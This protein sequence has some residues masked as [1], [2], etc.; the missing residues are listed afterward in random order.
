MK[1]RKITEKALGAFEKSLRTEEKSEH[2][3]EKYMRDIR[4]FF[5]FVKNRPLNKEMLLSYKA[6]LA[7]KYAPS[8]ANSM[9]AAVNSF[10]RFINRSDL[11][12]RQFKIQKKAYCS[13]TKELSQE[14]YFSLIKTAEDRKKER[15]SLLIQT[16]CSTGIRISELA[17]ITMEGVKKGEIV[18]SC[19]GKI[20]TVFIVSALQ[21]KLIQYA[22]KQGIV[23]GMIFVTKNNK[24][25]NRSNIWGEMK[26]L[27][28]EA[29]VLPDKVFPHNLRH[30]F[31]RTF[32][33]IEK[34]M[35]KLADI[36]GHSNLNTTR[37]Y[38][39]STGEEHRRKMENMRL[40]S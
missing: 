28:K 10:L 39:I 21:Q 14:E 2:T 12:I 35:A 16:I 4:C 24:P 17:F 29:G 9:L 11:S 36:L 8:S 38:I 13:A 31:A 30:L 20:R 22:R 37:I 32:Y 40:I 27:C 19:K 25:L 26:N 34:D 5:V 1:V 15:L 7:S 3:I 33:G 18:V 6:F 23:S